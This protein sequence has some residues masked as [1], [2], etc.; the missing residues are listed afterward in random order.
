[1]IRR[2]HRPGAPKGPGFFGEEENSASRPRR[3]RRIYSR[4]LIL[5]PSARVRTACRLGAQPIP[6]RAR[7]RAPGRH[8]PRVKDRASPR[9]QALEFILRLPGGLGIGKS[10]EIHKHQS[11]FPLAPFDFSLSLFI[12]ARECA[13]ERRPGSCFKSPDSL[14]RRFFRFTLIS[15]QELM[16]AFSLRTRKRLAAALVFM[17]MAGRNGC[18]FRSGTRGFGSLPP[19]L[20]GSPDHGPSRRTIHP[21]EFFIGEG[22]DDTYKDIAVSIIFGEDAPP[23]M[24]VQITWMKRDRR[25]RRVAVARSTKTLRFILEADGTRLEGDEPANGEIA[26]LARGLFTAV[27]NKKRLLGKAPSRGFREP[28]EYP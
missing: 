6:A 4:P 27:R 21:P 1:M 13:K 3:N 16:S 12:P 28:R 17:I 20:R 25:D 23:D 18:R 7:R 9:R 10:P 2:F 26:V 22:D 24:I 8:S 11:R 19:D 14:T 5:R 15:G